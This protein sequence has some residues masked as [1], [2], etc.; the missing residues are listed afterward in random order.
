MKSRIVIR[1]CLGIG[2]VAAVSGIAA[3]HT[4]GTRAQVNTSNTCSPRIPVDQGQVCANNARVGVTPLMVANAESF[5]ACIGTQG[6]TPPIVLHD[7][8]S[9]TFLYP[10]GVVP[11]A[12]AISYCHTHALVL[13]PAPQ[14]PPPPAPVRP[15]LI[16]QAATAHA[17]S[18]PAPVARSTAA[19]TAPR[20]LYSERLS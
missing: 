5:A 10:P 14:P 11:N 18:Q 4:L 16:P 2:A 13:K 17:A 12:A 7:P 15:T 9:I 19:S 1:I 6:A 20:Q 8:I 3:A